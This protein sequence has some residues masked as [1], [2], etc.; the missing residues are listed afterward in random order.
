M[1]LLR[2][3]NEQEGLTIV[4]VTHDESLARSAHRLVRLTEGRLELLHDAA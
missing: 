2:N 4:M 1:G 3:L